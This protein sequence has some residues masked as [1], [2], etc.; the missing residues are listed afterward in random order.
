MRFAPWLLALLLT[1]APVAASAAPA[2]WEVSDADSKVW[3]FGSVHVLPSGLAW[4]TPV[5][6]DAMKQSSLVYFE[7]DIG[8]LGQLGIVLKA[9]LQGFIA[10]DDWFS[11]L[12]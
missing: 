6:D 8:P 11:A 9:M 10:K 7:A 2:M 4:R 12:T 1:A 5:L 3:L